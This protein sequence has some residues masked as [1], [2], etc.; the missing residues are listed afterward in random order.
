MSS[1][2]PKSDYVTFS[3]Y[4]TLKCVLQKGMKPFIIAFVSMKYI[5]E[6]KRAFLSYYYDWISCNKEEFN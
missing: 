1:T 2:V 3:A 4:R 6:D 5:L